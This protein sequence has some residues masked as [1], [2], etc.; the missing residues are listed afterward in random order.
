MLKTNNHPAL[1]S[2][3]KKKTLQENIK[4]TNNIF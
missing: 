4:N 3:K 2:I 1:K